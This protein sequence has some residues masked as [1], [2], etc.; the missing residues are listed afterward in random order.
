MAKNFTRIG[1]EIQ[2][3]FDATGM[4]AG[5]ATLFA[6]VGRRAR[7][8]PPGLPHRLTNPSTVNRFG[9]CRLRTGA[10]LTHRREDRDD[11]SNQLE[12]TND[13]PDHPFWPCR[14]REMAH[15]ARHSPA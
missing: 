4:D 3:I 7:P 10:R 5:G 9:A 15:P 11:H 2:V 1:N 13:H 12:K 14:R 6:N 8:H